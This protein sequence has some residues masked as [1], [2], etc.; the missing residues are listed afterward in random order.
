MLEREHQPLPWPSTTWALSYNRR[1]LIEA[2]NAQTRF[3]TANANRAFIQ[4]LSPHGT[5]LLLA[6]FIAPHSAIQLHKWHTKKGLP[7]PWAVLTGEAPDD[8]PLGRTTRSVRGR[9]RAPPGTRSTRT[10]TA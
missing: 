6:C 2:L 10:T 7:E 5:N 8:R 3:S 4:V 1:T 9:R